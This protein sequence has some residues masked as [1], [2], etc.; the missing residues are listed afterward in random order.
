[1]GVQQQEEGNTAGFQHSG[2]FLLNSGWKTAGEGGA[3]TVG[4]LGGRSYWRFV[5][6][7]SKRLREN[8]C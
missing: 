4:F 3:K 7:S 1:M 8:C 6:V 2:L 5:T